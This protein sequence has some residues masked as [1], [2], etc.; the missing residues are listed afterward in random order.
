M[1][2]SLSLLLLILWWGTQALLGFVLSLCQGWPSPAAQTSLCFGLLCT[3]L[4]LELCHARFQQRMKTRSCLLQV[5]CGTNPDFSLRTVCTQNSHNVPWHL[6]RK[7]HVAKCGLSRMNEKAGSY[8][9][10]AKEYP[11]IHWRGGIHPLK[12]LEASRKSEECT[13]R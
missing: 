7:I 4:S 11:L 13:R 9:A 6:T 3:L 10:G 12:K 8:T 1:P 5:A 2:C